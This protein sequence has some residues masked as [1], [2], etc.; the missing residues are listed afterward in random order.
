MSP[1]SEIALQKFI[2]DHSISLMALQETGNWM[3][4]NGLYSKQKVIQNKCIN[5][6]A[7]VALIVDKKLNPEHIDTIEDDTVDA[8]WCQIK[9]KN[10]RI[11]IGS[12]YTRPSNSTSGLENLLCHIKK[13][14]A[15]K[16]THNFNSIIVYGDFNARSTDWG[17]HTINKR[18]KL[19]KEFLQKEDMT[20]CSPYDYTFSCNNG[21]SVIDLTLASG[22][23]I[24]ELGHQWLEKE[25]ELFTGAPARGH[26]PVLQQ[27]L[28]PTTN[29]N[30]KIKC[31]LEKC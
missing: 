30:V 22:P 27:I 2:H 16:V 20:L 28:S 14:L 25:A 4:T 15:F 21:G 3:P 11:I 17:D 18:G 13:V 1:H 10:K 7:G 6:Q 12:V 29:S 8:V 5:D 24:S 9:L 31:R 26:Y 23:V 19:L